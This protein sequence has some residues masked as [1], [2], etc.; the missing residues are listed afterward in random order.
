M[1]VQAVGRPGPGAAGALPE[2]VG[3]WVAACQAGCSVL[4]PLGGDRRTPLFTL[5]E[6]LLLRRMELDLSVEGHHVHSPRARLLS[7]AIKH[8][9]GKTR[10]P[11]RLPSWH[12]ALIALW[13]C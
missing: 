3:D 9:I 1:G 4:P 5:A 6:W 2:G 11:Y 7:T 8:S 12:W 10:G 13:L